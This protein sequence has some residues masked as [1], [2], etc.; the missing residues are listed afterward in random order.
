MIMRDVGLTRNSNVWFT[1]TFK[2]DA[3]IVRKAAELNEKYLEELKTVVPAEELVTQCLFQPLPTS[4]SD[5]SKS[6]GGNILGLD[7]I[8]D[9]ALMWL[10]TVTSK[11]PEHE[12]FLLKTAKAFK[13]ELNEF[14]K[15]EGDRKS[16]V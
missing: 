14:A 15:S 9:N 4:F 1:L 6:R 13:N 3:R 8:S 11:T 10:Y 16:V 2:N 12:P 5:I 7:Q